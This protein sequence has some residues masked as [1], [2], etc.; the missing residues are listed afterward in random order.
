[1][2]PHRNGSRV[3]SRAAPVLAAVLGAYVAAAAVSW[4]RVVV[5]GPSMAPTLRAGEV[6][7]T[8]PLPAALVRP[9]LAVVASDPADTAHL[10][11]KRVT[12]VAR[13]RVFLVGDDPDHST[14]SRVWGWV[15]VSAVRRLVLARWPD[16]RTPLHLR[17]DA[18]AAPPAPGQAPASGS[19]GRRARTS[20]SGSS[21]ATSPASR[22]P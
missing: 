2:P 15:P 9:G 1:M 16:L 22:R 7:L 20:T 8:V 17:A 5:R 21:S 12:G 4:S 13:D 10:V 14:D 11:V 3:G 18:V 6:L 19:P